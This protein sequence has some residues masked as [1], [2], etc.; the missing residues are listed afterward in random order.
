MGAMV[1]AGILVAGMSRCAVRVKEP[2]S[3]A[4]SRRPKSSGHGKTPAPSPDSPFYVPPPSS[5]ALRW[6]NVFCLIG[7]FLFASA[8]SESALAHGWTVLVIALVV[9]CAYSLL[10]W[11]RIRA[12]L[13][14][15]ARRRAGGSS[16][17]SGSPAWAG[18]ADDEAEEAARRRKAAWARVRH[19]VFP[20]LSNPSVLKRPSDTWDDWKD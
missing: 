4:W 14:E 7:P 13:R 6:S 12:I 11:L 18:G 2:Q 20:I 10:E 15:L 9:L 5:K 1:L 19:D 17:R 3:Y 16:G 8:A